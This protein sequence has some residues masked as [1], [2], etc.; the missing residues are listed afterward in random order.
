MHKLFKHSHFGLAKKDELI[1]EDS[2]DIRIYEDTLIAVLCDGV[3]S[4]IEGKEAS[5]RV[6]NYLINN[7][8][9]KVK[10]WDI[11]KTLKVFIEQCN[12][13]LYQESMRE[14][15]SPEMITTLVVIVISENRLYG[16]NVGDS[17]LYLLRDDN[18][19]QLC[20]DHC[21]EQENMSHI[22]TQAIGLSDDVFP[23]F[24]EN[25]L[26]KN[27]KLLLCSDG[28]YDVLGD[29]KIKSAMNKDAISLVKEAS[30]IVDDN[31]PDDTSAIL[32]EVKKLDTKQ[33]SKIEKLSIPT[34]LKKGDDFDGYVLDK[35]LI[36]N[37]RTWLAY[38]NK[39]KF[40]LKFA[41]LEAKDD[42]AISDLFVHE[43][44]NATKLD[45]PCLPYANV[46]SQRSARYYIM[47]FV[48]G[49]TLEEFLENERLSIDLSVELA[50][51]LLKASQSL[52]RRDLIHGDIKP[53]NIMIDVHNK[54]QIFRLIDYGSIVD[55]FSIS[56]RAGTPSYIAP[57]RF[58][59]ESIS[60]SSEVYAIGVTLYQALS[61][62]LPYGEIEPFANP[63]FTKEPKDLMAY[64]KNIPEWLNN[65]I[66]KMVSSDMDIRYNYYSQVSYDFMHPEKVKPFFHKNKTLLERYP[67]DIYRYTLI[68][69]LILHIIV[70]LFVI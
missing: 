20:M 23:Y 38:N 57:E 28:V 32:V 33:K 27:D 43:V 69:S 11:P 21:L 54:E 25:D 5:R 59:N 65:I 30:S 49:I 56:S 70:W 44:L 8:K 53:A 66:L 64:N 13:I 39:E 61:K 9:K 6:V 36:A 60:E 1:S 16:A 50:L 45:L 15:E 18:I 47:E 31:L 48:E 12:N 19:E 22:L 41:P 68:A 55:V 3:G 4:A 26:R 37:D 42:E 24:F 58:K 62:E 67:V 35:S 63:S 46:S 52:I 17:H 14:Y 40:I 34:R 2:F 10:S 51:F 7:F 29:N